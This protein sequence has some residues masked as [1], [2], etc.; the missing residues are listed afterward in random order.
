M[1]EYHNGF[2]SWILAW[3]RSRTW[4]VSHL[5]SLKSRVKK[6]YLVVSGIFCHWKK[7]K[8]I[9]TDVHS[10]AEINAH[11]KLQD[12][13][14]KLMFLLSHHCLYNIYNTHCHHDN[15]IFQMLSIYLILLKKDI[16]CLCFFVRWDIYLSSAFWESHAWTMGK[17][18]NRKC[19]FSFEK[20]KFHSLWK[21]CLPDFILPCLEN[22]L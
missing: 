8:Q 15:N 17:L 14:L 22:G 18:I 12:F 16:E 6:Y 10:S 7:K 13:N 20:V 2:C 5:V 21:F 19:I 1:W 11:Y 4:R 3:V 9:K